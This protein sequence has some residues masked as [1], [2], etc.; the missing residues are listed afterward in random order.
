[1]RRF[2]VVLL[3]CFCPFVAKAQ[4]W[5]PGQPPPHARPGVDYPVKV[6][7]YGIHLRDEY[8][9]SGQRNGV[10]YADAIMD[11]KKIELCFN[12]EPYPWFHTD[13]VL[14]GD[15]QARLLK[16][17]PKKGPYKTSDPRIDRQYEF[18]MPDG[19]LLPSSVTG[20]WE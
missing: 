1:M 11:G 4:K 14:P 9:G 13:P 20:I 18:V 3:L 2:L 16:D 15:Y 7:I 12:M 17:S 8:V 6:H 10:V 5:R 19:T